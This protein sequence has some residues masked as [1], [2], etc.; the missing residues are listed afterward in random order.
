MDL[1]MGGSKDGAGAAAA[2]RTLKGISMIHSLSLKYLLKAF[3][4][5]AYLLSHPPAG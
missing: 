4:D 3:F 5:S 2:F 1:G